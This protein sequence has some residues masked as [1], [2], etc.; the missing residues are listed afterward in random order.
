VVKLAEL[1]DALP[2]ETATVTPEERAEMVER[3]REA[4][5]VRYGRQLR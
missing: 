4:I 2:P 3:R 1:R 5:R